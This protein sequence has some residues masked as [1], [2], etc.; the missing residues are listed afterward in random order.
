MPSAV[1]NLI[2]LIAAVLFILGLK[3]LAHPRTAVRANLL[4]AIG[5]L[6]AVIV[7]LFDRNIIGY[8]VIIAGF[9]RMGSVIGRFLQA[10]GIQATYLDDDPDNVDFLRRLGF[11]VYYGD[12]S[13]HNLLRTAGAQDAEIATAAL[14][15]D[16]A[17]HVALRR[18]PHPAAAGAQVGGPGASQGVEHLL[19][20][21]RSDGIGVDCRGLVAAVGVVLQIR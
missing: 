8:E 2:Y 21:D 20:G 5:M 19:G 18:L 6:L 17:R 3:G 4:G 12:A 10:N 15:E 7:T 16:A 1:V 13:R 9:G 14:D 11:K